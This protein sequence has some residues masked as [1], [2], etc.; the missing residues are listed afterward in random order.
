MRTG[1]WFFPDAPSASIVETIVAAEQLGLDEVWLG[2]EGPARDPFA[3]LAAA[4]HVTRRIRLGIGVTN[5]YLRH[6]TV[7][8]PPE[9]VTLG[10]LGMTLWPR[11]EPPVAQERHRKPIAENERSRWRHGYQRACEVQPR[12]PDTLV[13]SGADREGAI[14]EWF[15]EALRRAPEA[16][17]EF[18]I[19]AKCTRRIG[20]GPPPSS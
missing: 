9:R 7:A 2:D 11:P 6:P 15:L 20:T 10:G 17:A 14:Q 12:G 1:V 16:R 18:S 13:V 4:A 19:R 8:F 3:L 5:P